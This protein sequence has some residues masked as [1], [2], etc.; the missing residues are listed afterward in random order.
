M[1]AF[2]ELTEPIPSSAS[3]TIGVPSRI[4]TIG[5][6]PCGRKIMPQ[7]T[8]GLCHTCYQAPMGELDDSEATSNAFIPST[9]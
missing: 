9:D 8:H 1:F 5:E 4:L 2:T 3:A 7:L 6:V